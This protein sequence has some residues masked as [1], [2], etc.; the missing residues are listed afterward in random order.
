MDSPGIYVL[1]YVCV[2]ERTDFILRASP[3]MVLEECSSFSE[4]SAF[5]DQEGS[6]YTSGN[7]T[8]VTIIWYI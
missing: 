8:G 2:N 4:L 1:V 3:Y 7:S 5:Q 6:T